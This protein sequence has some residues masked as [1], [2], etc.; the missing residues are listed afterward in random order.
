MNETTER[1][2]GAIAR[3]TTTPKRARIL[4]IDDEHD[5]LVILK[6]L[7]GRDYELVTTT[8]G[9]RAAKIGLGFRPNLIFLD[10]MMP[11]I[12]GIEVLAELKSCAQLSAV[13]V[14]MLTSKSLIGDIEDAFE[15]G[16]DDY[17][18]KTLDIADFKKRLKHKLEKWALGLPEPPRPVADESKP[19]QVEVV[20]RRIP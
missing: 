1:E 2:T 8:D 12:S 3:V 14:V 7:L 5:F 9:R 18:I 16:A 20:R 15:L 11:G 19:T 13:P 17:L 4:A 10:W 6:G